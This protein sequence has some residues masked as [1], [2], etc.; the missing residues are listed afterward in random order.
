LENFDNL[1]LSKQVLENL[2]AIGLTKPTPIQAEAIPHIVK[3]RDL[4]GLAQTG[5]GKTAAFGLPMVTRLI[6][7]GKRPTPK[8]VRA[9]GSYT[10]LRAHETGA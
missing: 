1:G 5:T 3:G 2:P 8:S 9:P 7:Y 6:E 4:L 10:H